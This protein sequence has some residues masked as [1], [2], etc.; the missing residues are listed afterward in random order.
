MDGFAPRRFAS[1]RPA[2][3]AHGNPQHRVVRLL[4]RETAVQIREIHDTE[5]RV[6]MAA[7]AS[8]TI[9]A[10]TAETFTTPTHKYYLLN[11]NLESDAIAEWFADRDPAGKIA[12]LAV[13]RFTYN[14]KV[15]T[16]AP[17]QFPILQSIASPDADF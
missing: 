14:S 13:L 7:N 4:T 12:A 5:L 9:A 10:P 17:F 8:T 2:R 16:T 1:V 11:D 15:F 3:T 6:T